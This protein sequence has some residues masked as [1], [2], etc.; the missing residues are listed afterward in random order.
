MDRESFSAAARDIMARAEMLSLATRGGEPYPMIRGLFNLRN[1]EQFPGLAPFF[2][3]KGLAVY[4][5][6]N[7]SSVKV[8]ELAAESWASVYF[9]IP[10]EFKGLMLSGHAVPDESAR[11]QLW[12]E[13]WDRYY[14]RG[15]R[16][17]DYT[18]L[19]LDPVR[20]RGW[21]AGEPFDFTV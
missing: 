3:D 6:T 20:A 5:G 17:P 15:R 11:E 1:P 7:T 8:G 13:G 19:R 18:V 14:A 9:M 10:G 21:Y 12:V 16:D 2:A 4:L